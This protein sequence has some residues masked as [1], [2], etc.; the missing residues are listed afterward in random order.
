MNTSPP[1]SFSTRPKRRRWVRVVAIV[2]GVVALVAVAVGLTVGAVWTESWL[3]LGATS[4]PSLEIG[5]DAALGEGAPTAPAGVTTALVALVEER[6]PTLPGQ[7]PVVGPVALV[8]AGGPRGDDAAVV[9]LPA[10]LPV[11]V[12]GE[13]TLPLADV[14]ELGGIDLLTR[15]VVDHTGVAIDHVVTADTGALPAIVDALD[16][17]EVCVAV[18]REEGPDAARARVDAYVGAGSPAELETAFADLVVLTEAIAQR[19]TPAATVRSPLRTRRVVDVLAT[20]VV[21][22]VPLRGGAALPVAARLADPGGVAV[23]TLPGV[24]NPDSGA[25]VV[26]PEQAEVRFALL[27]DGGVP[28]SSAEA[29]DR[30]VLGQ[31][32]AAVQNG[33]GTTGYAAALEARLLA[34]GVRVAGTENAPSFDVE[35]TTV[36]YHVEDPV[37]EVAAVLLAELLGGDVLLEP[38][39]RVPTFE[40]EPVTVVV[41]GGADLDEEA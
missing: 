27:R 7:P 11:A 19:L 5:E 35:R 39:D 26:L 29:D 16:G 40:G 10:A 33:T 15:A 32:T 25:L 14:H 2:L 28:D 1:L 41:V 4:V 17:V 20:R 12:D 23:A 3:R 30:A 22:D 8:Q 36:R 31:V 13:G 38:A 21:T 24:V 9:L 18:C 37:G 34:A 6:D